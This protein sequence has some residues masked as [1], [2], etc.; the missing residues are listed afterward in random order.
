[1]RKGKANAIAASEIEPSWPMNQTSA[2]LT[3]P[4]TKKARVLGAAILT[5]KGNGFAVSRS[6][7]FG[8]MKRFRFR[9]CLKATYFKK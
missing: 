7:V 3:D 2:R 5:N 1:M 4:W 8:S 9:R 6:W